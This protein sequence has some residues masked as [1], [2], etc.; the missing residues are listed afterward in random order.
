MQQ[1]FLRQEQGVPDALAQ[2]FPAEFQPERVRK[3][4]LRDAQRK[5]LV[6]EQAARLRTAPG[7]GTGHLGKRGVRRLRQKAVQKGGV[8]A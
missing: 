2:K 3:R 6:R 8:C 7:E 4:R 5:M 1:R